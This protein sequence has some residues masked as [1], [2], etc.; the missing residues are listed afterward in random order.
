[1]NRSIASSGTINATDSIDSPLETIAEQIQT[2]VARLLG[3][4]SVDHISV[5]R[6]I[7][8][9]GMDSLTALALYNW[10]GREMNVFV[11][12][13]VLLQDI[14]IQSIATYVYDKLKEQPI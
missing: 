6:S 4:T 1:V 3:L 9:Q 10:L 5:H 11:P 7:I 13:V 2:A 8:S 12:L 14:P